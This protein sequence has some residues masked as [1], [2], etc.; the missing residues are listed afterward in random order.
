ME[1]IWANQSSVKCTLL[2]M[3]HETLTV[4]CFEMNQTHFALEFHHKFY[5][6]KSFAADTKYDY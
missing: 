6:E 2:V 4:L 5:N 3:E 1:Q